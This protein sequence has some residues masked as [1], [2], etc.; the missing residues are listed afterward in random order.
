MNIYIF[1]SHDDL[2]ENRGKMVNPF[3][4]LSLEYIIRM[5]VSTGGG[6][7]FEVGLFLY[8]KNI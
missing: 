4:S 2:Y 5:A 1:I 7:S 3:E 6:I 8:L